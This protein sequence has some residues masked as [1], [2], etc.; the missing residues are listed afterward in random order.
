MAPD[1]RGLGEV[2]AVFLKLG[3]MG[4]GGP[5]AHV[6]LTREEVVKRRGWLT[7]QEF[8]D[9][10]GASNVVPGPTSTEVAIHVGAHRAGWRGLLV[11]GACFIAPAFLIVLGLAWMY[12][13]YGADPAAVDL[14]YGILPIVLAVIAHA[15]FGLLRSAVKS[16]LLG[17]VAAAAFA[18]FLLDVNEILILAAGG[19]VVMLW[20]NRDRLRP[21]ATSI[22]V[23][24]ALLGMIGGGEARIVD[25][26]LGR[27]F[28]EFLKFGALVFGSGY[29]LVAFLEGDLVDANHWIT[30]QQLLDAI[31][32]GQVTPGP[33]FTTATFVGFQIAG[34]PGAVLATLGI[35]LP[36]F[37]FVGLLRPIVAWARRSP[38]AGGALDGVT[39]ASLGLMAGVTVLLAD[40]AFPDVLTIAFGVAALAALLWRRVNP[41]WLVGAGA[42]V[43]GAHAVLT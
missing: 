32:V 10:L 31:A 3:T 16:V 28:L 43:G 18:A 9:F 35:F 7:D 25:P 11:A 15:V 37:V 41:A 36:A 4:F 21:G 42:I 23:P 24:L 30:R 5:A 20:A 40:D 33:V 14:R 1:R 12:E 17:L 6:A 27:L 22:V 13:R 39:G 29:V 8:L 26:G 2:A 19:L 34:L 38:W